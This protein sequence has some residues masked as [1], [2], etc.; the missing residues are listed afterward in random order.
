M[1]ARRSL[2]YQFPGN[3]PTH[4]GNGLQIQISTHS[5]IPIY[6]GGPTSPA[7]NPTTA[8][9][10]STEAAATAGMGPA[11]RMTRER[12]VAKNAFTQ[13]ASKAPPPHLAASPSLPP[14]TDE[15]YFG[16]PA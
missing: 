6:F 9:E 16:M 5:G 15:N 13:P 14:H 1:E 3:E 2:N 7:T 4:F 12:A 11:A 10:C 8:A